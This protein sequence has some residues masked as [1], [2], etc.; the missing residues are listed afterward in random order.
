[1]IEIAELVVALDRDDDDH[2]PLGLALADSVRQLQQRFEQI[3]S[4]A[5]SGKQPLDALLQLRDIVR[6]LDEGS[7]TLAIRR[8]RNLRLAVE[9]LDEALE[10]IADELNRRVRRPDC[11]RS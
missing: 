5:G 8:Q 10:S 11:R 6:V 9:F 1:M 2:R 3:G 4:G 7:R